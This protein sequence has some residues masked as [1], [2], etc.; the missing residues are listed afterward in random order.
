MKEIFKE[1]NGITYNHADTD[2]TYARIDTAENP[3]YFTYKASN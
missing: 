2:S 1:K 3:G